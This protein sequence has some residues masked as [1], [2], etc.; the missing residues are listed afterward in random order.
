MTKVV[1]YISKDKGVHQPS[2][3]EQ[4]DVVIIIFL[5]PLLAIIMP[6]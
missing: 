6:N 3:K 2:L 5:Q 1:F 4:L